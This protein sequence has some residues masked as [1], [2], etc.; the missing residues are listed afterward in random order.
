M[1]YDSPDLK[2]THYVKTFGMS[3][4]PVLHDGDIVYYRRISFSKI[5][6]D[7]IIVIK[8]GR[9]YMTHRVVYRKKR[10]VVTK[11]DN[12]PMPE[13]H[14]TEKQVVGRVYKFKRGN[15]TISIDSLYLMQS[16]LYFQEILKV[17]HAFE[18]ASIDMIFLKGLPLYLY[19]QKSHPPRV[20]ADC[21]VMIDESDF[22]KAHSIL[23]SSGYQYDRQEFSSIHE[24]LRGGKKA[25]QSYA[26]LVGGVPVV[27]DIHREPVFMISK[28]GPLTELYPRRLM[29]DLRQS[30]VHTKRKIRIHNQ[31]FYILS[32]VSLIVYLAL[33][34][35]NH[36]FRGA[37]RYGLLHEIY[38]KEY[39][40][41]REPFIMQIDREIE[42]YKLAG[43]VSLP[44]L[45]LRKYYGNPMPKS[46]RR[47]TKLKHRYLSNRYDQLSRGGI[48]YSDTQIG[49]GIQ[50]FINLVMLSP[51]PWWRR[52]MILVNIRV[53]AMIMW[54]LFY[55]VKKRLS[56]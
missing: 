30:F 9:S 4:F 47:F 32:P 15:E 28:I 7:D 18:N 24:R 42:T 44:F 31:T 16:S 17:K 21:D 19:Y 12:A 48:F 3:M 27:F 36:D 37:Y 45:L 29:E 40:V 8:H 43:F 34:L 39:A 52:M 51:E 35:F 54:I 56:L 23:T 10:Y 38:R 41:L 6:V 5:R 1:K 14:V 33:H 20:Y 22:E 11:G 2:K 55:S 49:G 13:L 25:E 53:H 26:K 46:I 50:R